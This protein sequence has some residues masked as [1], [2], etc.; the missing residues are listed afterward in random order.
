[1][2]L[3][4]VKT[5][6]LI[7]EMETDGH[8]P[9]KIMCDDKEIYFCKY[10]VA[11]NREELTCLAYEIVASILLKKLEIPTPDIALVTISKDT[12][13]KKKI[14]KNKRLREG[15]ICFGSKNVSSS[16]VLNDFATITNKREFN[17][18]ANPADIIRIAIFD[19]WVN[20]M[21]R[22]RYIDPGFNYNILLKSEQKKEQVVAFDHGFI[23]GGVSNI[24]IFNE[25]I[26]LDKSNKFYLT[27]YYLEAIKYFTKEEFDNI[28]NKFIHLLCN[29]YEKDIQKI[30]EQLPKT[31]QLAPNLS[32]QIVNYLKSEKR[33]EEIRSIILQS[34]S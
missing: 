1:M 24:G 28:A 26:P 10:L 8:S 33:L 29:N 30:F 27:P 32:D 21:D 22:G 20:N 12:L 5:T 2:I 9:L 34:K 25:R 18:L 6:Y 4:H 15:N 19:L 31:W 13:E 11:I 23:F 3:K 16:F 17:Q 7:E 14:K